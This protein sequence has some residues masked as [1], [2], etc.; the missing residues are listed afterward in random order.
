MNLI[1]INESNMIA[2]PSNGSDMRATVK[3]PQELAEQQSTLKSDLPTTS[4]SA[5]D[6]W[7]EISDETE[8][9]YPRTEKTDFN[10]ESVLT[11]TMDVLKDKAGEAYSTLNNIEKVCAKKVTETMNAVGLSLGEE[12]HEYTELV[13]MGGPV[14]EKDLQHVDNDK[15]GTV[16][17]ESNS[18]ENN[19]Q[20]LRNARVNASHDASG[21]IRTNITQ[22]S[23]LKIVYTMPFLILT[24]I[25]LGMTFYSIIM[26]ILLLFEKLKF[27]F[28]TCVRVISS[29]MVGI[30]GKA[31][32]ECTLSIFGILISDLS[33][34][35]T[36]GSMIAIVGI[37]LCT[38]LAFTVGPIYPCLE[39]GRKFGFSLALI[40]ISLLTILVFLAY[41]FCFERRIEKEMQDKENIPKLT[42]NI[43]AVIGCFIMV[44]MF[45]I[46]IYSTQPITPDNLF[47]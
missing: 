27:S 33:D 13:P 29:L 47:I 30:F 20:P 11:K 19:S 42:K 22:N 2:G 1:D 28:K 40:L 25:L 32:A 43:K 37:M 16:Y 12:A 5:N 45:V 26:T 39:D 36:K 24:S 10:K 7:M 3:N 38:V 8:G 41:I 34:R 31:A 6:W 4:A 46:L 14:V 9:I 44:V 15:K 23:S 17:V 35:K 18:G 21:L